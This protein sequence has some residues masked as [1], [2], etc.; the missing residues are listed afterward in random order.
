MIKTINELKIISDSHLLDIYE[1]ASVFSMD[2][3]NEHF[4]TEITF[5]DI[6]NELKSRNYSL[7][8]QKDIKTI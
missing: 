1:E 6:I 8:W 4:K 3:F 7:K 5:K 2:R